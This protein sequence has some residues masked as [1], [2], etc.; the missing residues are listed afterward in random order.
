MAERLTVEQWA[1]GEGG[2]GMGEVF[3]AIAGAAARI[4]GRIRLAGLDDVYG[5]AG[6]TNVQG[7]QQQ[8]LD[9]FANEAMTEALRGCPSVVGLVS[10]EEEEPVSISALPN[11][12]R[13]APLSMPFFLPLLPDHAGLMNAY[14]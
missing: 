8:K 4:A 5:A 1:A 9:V 2:A 11:S 12:M 6:A 3:G 7:E 10:E 14:P 13:K